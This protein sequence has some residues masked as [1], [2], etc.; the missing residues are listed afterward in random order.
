MNSCYGIASFYIKNHRIVTRDLSFQP[1]W[2]GVAEHC[3]SDSLRCVRLSSRQ[4]TS[5][6]TPAFEIGGLCRYF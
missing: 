2:L 1:F 4:K 3:S 5:L 6:K